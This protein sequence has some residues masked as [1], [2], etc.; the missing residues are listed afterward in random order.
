MDDYIKKTDIADWKRFSDLS[1]KIKFL[2]PQSTKI[3]ELKSSDAN[4]IKSLLLKNP[5]FNAEIFVINVTAAF[6]MHDSI[7]FLTRRDGTPL[8]LKNVTEKDVFFDKYHSNK[9]TAT[10]GDNPSY[11]MRF[12]DILVFVKTENASLDGLKLIER[13]LGSLEIID[14]K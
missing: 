7:Q 14:E 8:T 1:S 11:F 4:I 9:A 3:E 6:N 5:Q 12:N 10:D 13:T 2:Y